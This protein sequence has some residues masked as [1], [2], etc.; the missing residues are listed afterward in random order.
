M[1]KNVYFESSI[2]V[3]VFVL[4][5]KHLQEKTKCKTTDAIKSLIDIQPS[6]ANIVVGGKEKEIN[7]DEVNVG[8]IVLVG[9]GEKYQFQKVKE[10]IICNA[11]FVLNLLYYMGYGMN[12]INI[13][14]N[15][16]RVI[17]TKMISEIRKILFNNKDLE[18]TLIIKGGLLK[19]A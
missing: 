3:I 2:F 8:D 18:I 17:T 7:I 15:D 9:P 1:Y 12:K 5:G 10:R 11:E 6:T 14:N 4:L 19:K 16:G 13:Y